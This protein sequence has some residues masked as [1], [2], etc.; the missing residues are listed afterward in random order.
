MPWPRTEDSTDCSWS[1]A[2]VGVWGGSFSEPREKGRSQSPSPFSGQVF[3]TESSLIG[4]YKREIKMQPQQLGKERR[5][6]IY[7]RLPAAKL[8]GEQRPAL[9]VFTHCISDLHL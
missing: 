1:T 6:I 3:C 4:L 7:E 5:Q 9:A 2:G 8:F